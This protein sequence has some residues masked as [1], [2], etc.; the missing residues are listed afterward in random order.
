MMENDEQLTEYV[1]AEL[2]P[3][4]AMDAFGKLM[5]Y[6]REAEITKREKA[7]YRLIE[8]VMITEITNRYQFYHELLTKTF[9]ERDKVIK[10]GFKI[11]DKGIKENNTE[12][13]NMGLKPIVDIVKESPFRN[14]Q[15]VIDR[16][17][18]HN[19]LESGGLSII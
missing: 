17:E 14:I 7:K 11:I 5:D 18:R 13:I 15:T 10:E 1:P 3:S 12:L 9:A 16:V 8:N 2:D 4:A 19:L 6:A